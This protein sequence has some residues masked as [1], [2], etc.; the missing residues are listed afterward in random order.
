MEIYSKEET[1]K[2]LDI[3][4]NDLDNVSYFSIKEILARH[5]EYN[6]HQQGALFIEIESFGGI[7]NLFEKIDDKYGGLFRLTKN[8]IRLKEYGK[9][10]NAF[11]KSLQPKWYNENWVGYVVAIITLFFAVYQW[12][13]NHSLKKDASFLEKKVDSL[14][15]QHDSLSIQFLSL[16]KKLSDLK[17]KTEKKKQE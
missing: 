11:E 3:V 5:R 4:I 7:H 14:I 8:G 13:E 15:V 2:V 9:G 17:S 10:F 1:I 16:E 6:E 12:S